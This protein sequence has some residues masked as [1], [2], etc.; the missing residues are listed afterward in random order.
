MFSLKRKHWYIIGLIVYSFLNIIVLN[1]DRLY[2]AN[3]PAEYLLVIV[4]YLCYGIWYINL[5]IERWIGMNYFKIHPIII[6]FFLSVS[7]IVFLS[8]FSV[9]LTSNILGQP[10]N[11]IQQNVML[12]AGFAF[13]V[14]LFL[15][16]INAVYFYNK[17]FREKELEAEK[18]K[19]LTLSAKY[20]AL[21]NQINPHFLF[22]CLNTLSTLI[23]SDHKRANTFLHKLSDTYRYLLKTNKEELVPL[24]D[25]VKFLKDY[26]EL[27]KIRF[28]N[29][30]FI[31]VDV[32]FENSNKLLPPTV[33]QLLLENVVKHN[34][35]TIKEPINVSIVEV[36]DEIQVQNKLQKKDEN[37]PSFGVGLKN[38]TARYEFFNK[39]ITVNEDK[40]H[41]TVYVP[42]IAI[43][44][45]VT[46][47]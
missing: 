27:L 42:T 1:G 30:I 32:D 26:I 40:E 3:L 25:E 21:N 35:F 38:I 12:T 14:N 20:E 13:R 31:D 4:G 46:N 33:L 44:D 10:F 2:S 43:A 8:V 22:N 9:L 16:A 29:S 47:S 7:G 41:Y 37:E 15:N 11:F 18:L 19:S 39:S 34:Y 23:N 17:K 36:G 24:S 28:E 6:Q 5:L 45:E